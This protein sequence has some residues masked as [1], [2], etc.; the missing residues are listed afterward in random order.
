MGVG[1][2]D[3]VSRR[4]Q[5]MAGGGSGTIQ[6][7]PTRRIVFAVLASVLR[8]AADKFA[9]VAPTVGQSNRRNDPAAG[10]AIEPSSFIFTTPS[11]SISLRAR[12]VAT[13]SSRAVSCS[14]V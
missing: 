5:V 6:P 14:L 10:S 13:E 12:V 8:G 11:K 3:S 7:A 2:I 9:N 4:V 1:A